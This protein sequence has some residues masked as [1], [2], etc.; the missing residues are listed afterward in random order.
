MLDLSNHRDHSVYD[1]W[2]STFTEASLRL[3]ALQTAVTDLRQL[4]CH[5]ENIRGAEILEVLDQHGV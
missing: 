3:D 4:L 2:L 1:R 5:S